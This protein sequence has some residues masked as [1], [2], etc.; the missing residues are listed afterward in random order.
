MVKAQMIH[1]MNVAI[2][3]VAIP[4]VRGTAGL[5]QI[6]CEDPAGTLV[7]LDTGWTQ[8]RLA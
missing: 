1:H 8:E 2:D 6:F 7:E 3:E 5:P 4:Y